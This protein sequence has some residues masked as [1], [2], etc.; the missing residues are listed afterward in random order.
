[1]A[2]PN[3]FKLFEQ[4]DRRAASRAAC[5]AGNSSA[6]RTPIMAITTSS[7][8]SVNARRL[9]IERRANTDIIRPHEKTRRMNGSGEMESTRF[10]P[11]K[12]IRRTES[13]LHRAESPGAKSATTKNIP[14]LPARSK[15]R[16]KKRQL[17]FFLHESSQRTAWD[18]RLVLVPYL[19]M[20]GVDHNA[21]SR[22]SSF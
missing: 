8:T 13:P 10:L 17:V 19:R 18:Q 21:T 15:K 4:L 14:K 9:R 5:T 3:C 6:T 20:V 1:M 16:L 12:G 2:I 22:P 11:P 7:S